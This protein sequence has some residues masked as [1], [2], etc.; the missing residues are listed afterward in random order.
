MGSRVAPMSLE[1]FL[2]DMKDLGVATDIVVQ[3]LPAVQG[4]L[5]PEV[6]SNLSWMD[7]KGAFVTGQSTG[8]KQ[9]QSIEFKEFIIVLALCGHIKYEEVA[10]M[11]LAQRVAGIVA[12][13][14][15]EKNEQQVITEAVV[16]AVVRF[17]ASG[18]VPLPGQPQAEHASWLLTWGQM[19][20]GHVYGFPLWEEEVFGLLRRSFGE[21]T[22]IFT[23]Y[24]KSGTAG[25]ASAHAAETLQQTELIDLVLDCGLASEAFPMAR[26]QN[27]FERA[28][29][30]DDKKG[31]DNALELHEFLEC[32]VMLSFHRANPRFGEVG[33]ER[34]AAAPLPGCLEGMLQKQLLKRAKRDSLAKVKIMVQRDPAVQLALRPHRSQLRGAFKALCEKDSTTMAGTVSALGMDLFLHDLFDRH[35]TKEISVAPTSLVKGEVLP[36]VH[37]NL[38]WMDAKGAFVTCQAAGEDDIERQTLGFDEFVAC[39]AL[40]GHIKYEEVAEMS[41]AQRVAGIVANYLGEKNEQQ[42]ITEAVVPAVVRFDASGAVPLPGQPQA[43]H[44]SWLLTWGQMDLGHVYG[45]PL[46]E[47]E[48]FGLLRRSFGELTSIFTHYAKS[49]TAGSASA[50]AAETLQQT[51]LID[52]VLDC[53]LA[54]EA[55]PMARVQNVFERA[56]QTD[57]KKG[58]DN[59][60][61]LHEFLECIV[62]LSFHRANPRFGE[63]GREGTPLPVCHINPS[64]QLASAVID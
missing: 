57:D 23:H 46:W 22:S 52:L 48:V 61:E 55:F 12:N 27:V 50:H 9:R 38:S 45:F 56:D 7:M 20:L 33:R 24:A 64:H 16:P 3:P 62:M 19:D 1:M 14:L 36:E 58:G 32:I 15:G 60:L 59:A 17:D 6:H 18:A 13:Y 40:C 42:V 31:G 11:S 53:G 21:L 47:E 2:Q 5:L 44:A 35:V 49:G 63:V 28:D 4:D 25:S 34:T 54:S 41:L 39:L 8:D 51:E 29:Q 43:E 26:V 30:T 37:S 10:E